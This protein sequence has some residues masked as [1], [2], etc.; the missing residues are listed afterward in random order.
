MTGKMGEFTLP[1][2]ENMG[3]APGFLSE[4]PVLRLVREGKQHK[5]TGER[6]I[7]AY[8]SFFCV[9]SKIILFFFHIMSYYICVNENYDHK[10]TAKHHSTKILLQLYCDVG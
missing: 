7:F 4:K 5:V 2:G 6:F 3:I 10:V 8:P 9:F 1:F